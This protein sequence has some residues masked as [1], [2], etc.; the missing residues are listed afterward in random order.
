MH[1]LKLIVRM[2]VNWWFDTTGDWFMTIIKRCEK[3]VH[4]SWAD[5][6]L[7]AADMARHTSYLTTLDAAVLQ[8]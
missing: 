2:V 8:Y 3:E 4:G 7:Q 6:Q 5:K 1:T